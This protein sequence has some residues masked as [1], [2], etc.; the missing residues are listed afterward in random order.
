[1]ILTVHE[2]ISR[3]ETDTWVIVMEDKL[4]SIQ[5]IKVQKLVDLPPGGFKL[6]RD[7][8]ERINVYKARF[9]A[10]GLI[11]RENIDIIE[12]FQMF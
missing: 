11:Y 8:K 3:K 5:P 2:E 7:T 4:K 6:H 9:V 1:M 10:K 12:T